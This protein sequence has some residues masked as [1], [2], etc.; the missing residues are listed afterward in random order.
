MKPI[1]FN[2]E[3][4]KAILD[5][6]KTVT[7]RPAKFNWGE[8]TEKVLDRYFTHHSGRY[9]ALF[10]QSNG[11]FSFHS[12]SNHEVGDILYVR[13]T[14]ML[15]GCRHCEKAECF[16]CNPAEYAYRATGDWD[17]DY[18]WKPSIHMPKS[19]ARIFLKVTDVRV[20]RVQDINGQ[21]HHD[22]VL[23]EGITVQLS[24][25]DCGY[26][27]SHKFRDIWQNL[28]G[29]WDANPWVWVYEFERCEVQP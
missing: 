10:H 1:L 6:R 26:T 15:W 13:E 27:P 20:E 22:D 17:S 5:G 7:R 8:D 25:L 9:T 12:Y 28:Y 21:G 18:K 19:A 11:S 29:D 24:E 3:M 2:T 14:F 4:V 16:S 23:K